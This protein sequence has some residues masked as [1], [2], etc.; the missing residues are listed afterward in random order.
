[1]KQDIL[2]DIKSKIEQ[3]SIDCPKQER[4]FVQ[5]YLGTKRKFL[6][7]K[8]QERDLIIRQTIKN[9]EVSPADEIKNTLNALLTSDVF[10]HVN[11]GGKLL[12]KSRKIKQVVDFKML[13]KWLSRTS[14]WA[15]CDSICQS[16]LAE[17]DVLEN[18]VEWQ[19]TILKFSESKNIQLRRASLVMQCKPARCSNNKEIRQ[20]A[21]KTIEKLKHERE[22]LITKAVSW[23][24]RSLAVN[25]GPE[26][27]KYIEKNKSSLPAIA[28]RE[29]LKKLKTGKK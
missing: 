8:S 4:L 16:L 15:E 29:T 21:F 27:S 12:T 13:E 5:K 17:E 23:L 6:N 22:T 9:L 1:M 25:N 7:L 10:E 19:E 2:E 14:G 20:M 26:V 18:F 28:Y 3:S 11:F 24:L